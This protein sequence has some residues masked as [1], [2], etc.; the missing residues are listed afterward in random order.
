MIKRVL[1]MAGGTGG[2]IFPG[3]ALATYLRDQGVEV[4]WL[5]T[6]QSMESRL[7][8][9]AHFPFHA[10]SIQG[11]RGKGLKALLLAP[12]NIIKAIKQ[13]R[14]VIKTVNPDVVIGMGGFV[15]G[16]GGVASWLMKRPLFIHE[17][18]A[19][20]GTTNRLLVYLA[21]TVF[22]GFPNVFKEN[23][24]VVTV[25]NPVRVEIE[26][27]PSVKERLLPIRTPFRLLVLGG[28]LGAE[29]LNKVVPETLALLKEEERPA[30][31]H[32]AGE[33]HFSSLKNHYESNNIDAKLTPFIENM[34]E[35]Y[36]WADLVLCRAGALTVSELCVAGLGAVFVPFPQAVD[37]HQTVNANV[38]VEKGAAICIQQSALTPERLADIVRQFNRWPEQRIAMAESA[39]KLRQT[40]VVE[41]MFAICQEVCP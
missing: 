8:P 20:A 15:S 35:A 1:I 4:A 22:E 39:Y 7:V 38:M 34:A 14:S 16:P 36:A 5:G 23:P 13:A 10:I 31:W 28:S 17:Q 30:V 3:L 40:K 6:P 2:H 26:N 37:D 9:A 11:V 29:M 32:Q 27:L 12:I 21:H 41:K 25:G 18:N 19:K 24:Q 33:K